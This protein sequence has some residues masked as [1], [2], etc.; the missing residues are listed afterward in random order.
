MTDIGKV[1]FDG[2]AGEIMLDEHSLPVLANYGPSDSY[3]SS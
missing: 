1:A 3:P 2:F